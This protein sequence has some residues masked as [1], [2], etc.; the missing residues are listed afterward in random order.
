[1]NR[2]FPIVEELY[3]GANELMFNIGEDANGLGG[4][5]TLNAHQSFYDLNSKYRLL[6]NDSSLVLDMYDVLLFSLDDIEEAYSRF[7]FQNPI[8]TSNTV[9]T[10]KHLK[11]S[12][13]DF[14][15]KNN[16]EV[17]YL[18]D[19]DDDEDPQRFAAKDRSLNKPL[20]LIHDA[21]SDFLDEYPVLGNK[22]IGRLIPAAKRKSNYIAISKSSIQNILDPVF[23][24]QFEFN[25]LSTIYNS[26]FEVVL[27]DKA[28]EEHNFVFPDKSIPNRVYFYAFYLIKKELEKSGAKKGFYNN[29][30]AKFLRATFPNSVPEISTLTIR[31]CSGCRSELI[32]NPDPT[33]DI[34]TTVAGYYE[35]LCQR[36]RK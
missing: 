11:R 6:L 34:K 25:D 13:S 9:G 19:H 20:S 30:L 27:R 28:P 18:Y 5:T 21:I 17:I 16:L 15:R 36:S 24:N 7:L 2:L 33:Q 8:V 4:A 22:P 1:M 31:I 35:A 32:T 14:T 29:V 3:R 26:L 10:L 23:K 12:I